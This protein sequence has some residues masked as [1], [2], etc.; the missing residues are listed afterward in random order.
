MVVPVQGRFIPTGVGNTG[1]DAEWHCIPAVH[2][3]GCGEHQIA[4]LVSE[5]SDGSSPRVW[6]TR[7]CGQENSLSRRFI[8]TGVGNTQ[9]WPALKP[10][11][12][13]HPHGC[14]EH[15]YYFR[16]RSQFGGSSPRVW[17]TQRPNGRPYR[18][19]RFIPTGVGN[20]V[21]FGGWRGVKTV[22]PHGC[23]E[24]SAKKDLKFFISGSSPRVWGTQKL[25]VADVP[26][27]RFIPTGVGNTLVSMPTSSAAPV[28]PHGCGEH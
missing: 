3:H 8:P 15:D 22:H 5:I 18:M 24:H 7:A 13:V 11:P 26:G 17:G 21:R 28:H 12:P 2:P 20:T 27:S 19:R 16:L 1:Y 25:S 10:R 9:G 6:G 4:E 14:G 23:G